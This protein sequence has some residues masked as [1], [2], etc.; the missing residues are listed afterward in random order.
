MRFKTNQVKTSNYP[1]IFVF[2]KLTY[3]QV[4]CEMHIHAID[5]I[6][7]M[8]A[9]GLFSGAVWVVMLVLSKLCL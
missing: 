7:L 6:S 8:L 4:F 1:A 9:S 5:I 3:P 2:I